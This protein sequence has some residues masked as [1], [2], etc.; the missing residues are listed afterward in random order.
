[1]GQ[2]SCFR[3]LRP[4]SSMN[5]SQSWDRMQA[6]KTQICLETKFWAQSSLLT[7]RPGGNRAPSH[8]VTPYWPAELQGESARVTDSSQ[9]DSDVTL[10]ANRRRSRSFSAVTYQKVPGKESLPSYSVTL[11]ISEAA[12]PR[13]RCHSFATSPDECRP[14]IGPGKG[15]FRIGDPKPRQSVFRKFFRKKE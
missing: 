5:G 3:P 15:E 11:Y 9:W 2:S 14:L 7:I 8:P 4:L 10:L 13:G 1:M 6:L 12:A